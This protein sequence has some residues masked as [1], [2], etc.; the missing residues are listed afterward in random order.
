M[1]LSDYDPKLAGAEAELAGGTGE[2]AVPLRGQS[3]ANA[4][5]Y[6]GGASAENLGQTP[7]NGVSRT[8]GGKNAFAGPR[9]RRALS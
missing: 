8:S 5:G 6:R 3:G 7:A 4:G 1:G 2:M 9:L